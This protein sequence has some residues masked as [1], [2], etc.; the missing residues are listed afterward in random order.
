[1]G[2]ILL[3]TVI[4]TCELQLREPLRTQVTLPPITKKEERNTEVNGT[5][6]TLMMGEHKC[7]DVGSCE[8]RN[9]CGKTVRTTM[10]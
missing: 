5:Y 7:I 3:P 10:K 9:V 1:M 6:F 4:I 2:T 8:L